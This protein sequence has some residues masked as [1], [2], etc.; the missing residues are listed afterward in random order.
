VVVGDRCV[1]KTS[2][3][4]TYSQGQFPEGVTPTVIDAYKGQTKHKG[5]IVELDVYDTAG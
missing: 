2:L 1:G 3:L 5:D 4:L